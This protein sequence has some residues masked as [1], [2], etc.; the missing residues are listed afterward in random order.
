[1]VTTKPERAGS[2]RRTL[3]LW[4]IVPLIVL[5]PASSALQYVLTI[6]PAYQ[7]FD[8]ALGDSVI[9]LSN[10]LKV[11]DTAVQFDI[12]PQMERSF[13]TDQFDT[14]YFAV[15]DGSGTLI[16]GDQALTLPANAL[17]SGQWRFMDAQIGGQDVRIAARGVPCGDTVCQIRVAE[18]L[19]KRTV[20]ARDVLTGTA[21]TV[22]ALMTIAALVIVLAARR[23][24][25]PLSRISAQVT[26]RSLDDLR[27]LDTGAAPR[28]THELLT[29]VNRL[30][31]RL[32][33]A[34]QAQRAFLADA[35]HQLRTPLTTLRTESEL[36]LREPHPPALQPSLQ[37]LNTAAVRAARLAEQLLSLARADPQAQ[38]AIAA[39]PLDLRDLA[40]DMAAEWVPRALA[41]D[42]DLGF[43]L[44]SA[45]LIGREVLLRE[46]LANLLDNA[47]EYAGRGAVITVRT[48]SKAAQAI[49]EVQDNGPGIAPADRERVWE[50]FFRADTATRAVRSGSGLGLAIVRDIA[51]QHAATAELLTPDD[52]QGTLMRL[53]F[54]QQLS[55]T[56][57]L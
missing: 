34:S 21:L 37:R 36:A 38:A 46:L 45:P 19:N 40:H 13:R 30:F 17:T 43:E 25:A 41:H 1:M 44:A 7:A 18:T 15:L 4:L 2:L 16:A 12:S 6:K 29:A 52:G 20:L 24:L 56:P 14:V 53:C 54:S 55:N 22:L 50:R 47:I 11:Q 5:V 9:G 42:S 8:A 10:F 48:Y 27:P 32:T 28:E 3:L 35:A 39:A 49:L 51:R 23:A 26:Q 33:A 31:E 57:R